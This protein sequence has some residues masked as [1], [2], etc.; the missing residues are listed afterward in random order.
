M[1][2]RLGSSNTVRCEESP[3][4]IQEALWNTVLVEQLSEKEKGWLDWM[5]SSWRVPFPNRRDQLQ[6]ESSWLEAVASASVGEAAVLA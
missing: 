6:C 5:I 2:A 1:L 3:G 4:P